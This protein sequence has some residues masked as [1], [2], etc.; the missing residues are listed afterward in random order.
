MVNPSVNLKLQRVVIAIAIALFI[1]KIIAWYLT[2]SIAILTDALESTVNIVAGS[3]S[4]WALYI[5]AKPRD[6][7]H[8][9]GHGKAEFLSAAVEGSLIAVAGGVIVYASVT[10]FLHP[11]ELK[12]LDSGI[13]LI[14][15]T[16]L[17]N[18]VTGYFCVHT[19]KKN[20][21][22]ALIATGRHLQTDT[23]STIGIIS[24]L[25]FIRFTHWR[26][27]DNVIAILLA[28][29][30]MYTG[31]RIVRRSVAGIMDEADKVLLQELVEL[32]NGNR[33]PNWID[34]HNLRIIKYGAVLHMDC[35]LTVPW[36][37]NVQ[38]AHA[39][40]ELLSALVKNKYGQSV[41]LFVHAD[42]CVASSC[43]VCTKA[44]CAVR[45][46]PFEKRIEWTIDNISRNKRHSYGNITENKNLH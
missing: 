39:E 14:S 34:L 46:H 12:Q 22:I 37:L 43:A 11:P 10:N 25:I 44:D 7:N 27:M 19:G 21:S 18:F 23:W 38:E 40:V 6:A 29:Y 26:W 33:R 2:R 24:G 32:L 4:L 36:Y 20:N 42:P 8:P 31:I 13:L 17:I 16:A 45:I 28:F 35:H 5:A 9:Y 3:V 41:E 1:I 30:I 15:A